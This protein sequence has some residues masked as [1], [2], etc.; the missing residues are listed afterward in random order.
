MSMWARASSSPLA[1]SFRG[2]SMCSSV[3]KGRMAVQT[4]RVLPFQ[5]SPTSRLVPAPGAKGLVTGSIRVGLFENFVVYNGIVNSLIWINHNHGL[6]CQD[7]NRFQ[8]AFA[9]LSHALELDWLPLGYAA[10]TGAIRLVEPV[11]RGTPLLKAV[12]IKGRLGP[13]PGFRPRRGCEMVS[14]G[15]ILHD[16]V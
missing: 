4:S 2:S 6:V 15:R 1:F 14:T 10:L 12:R 7:L 16:M 11:E 8:R 3:W 5:T 13:P 9:F